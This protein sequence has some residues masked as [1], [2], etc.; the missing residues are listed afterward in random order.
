MLSGSGKNFCAGIDLDSLISQV[1][2]VNGSGEDGGCPGRDRH[3]FRQFVFVLQDA[4]SAFEAC[5]VPVIAAVAGHCIGA[6]I[7]MITACDIRLATAAA[8]FS[9]K[10]RGQLQCIV[11]LAA[12][13]CAAQA[14]LALWQEARWAA[15]AA[16]LP[17][18]LSRPTAPPYVTRCAQVPACS[19]VHIRPPHTTP[20]PP[21]PATPCR[22]P[23]SALWQTWAPCSACPA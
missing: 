4:M 7:D 23:T 12:A 22:R 15:V 1:G 9:V 21:N 17:A 5:P 16:G 6:G 13:C 8:N 20:P 11:L 18:C 19:P 10:V 2:P 3:K 14:R